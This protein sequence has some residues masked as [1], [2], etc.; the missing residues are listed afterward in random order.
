MSVFPGLNEVL[1]LPTLAATALRAH[2][3]A[4]VA[5][6]AAVLSLSR[7]IGQLDQ[8]VRETR[9]SIATFQ[10]VG[11]RLESLLD[12]VEP[13]VRRCAEVLADP[14]VAEIPDTVSR[15][16]NDV[17]PVLATLRATSERLDWM[18]IFGSRRR[19]RIVHSDTG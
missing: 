11:T 2:A 16:R 4:A 14:A 15:I 6:P 19:P 1:R 5:L 7:A 12:G 13:G 3:E 17:L 8:T 9:E 18:P 10:R